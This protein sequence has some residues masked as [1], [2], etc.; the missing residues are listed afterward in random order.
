MKTTLVSDSS[1]Q[2]LTEFVFLATILFF[3]LSAACTLFKLE[4]QRSWCAYEAFES[5]HAHLTGRF[6]IST[7]PIQFHEKET[8]VEGLA[9]CGKLKEKV[10]LPKLET[11]KWK[12]SIGKAHE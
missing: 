7:V 2:T 5:T 4:W 3:I 10:I 8:T 9:I 1:G 12:E 11:A 6:K